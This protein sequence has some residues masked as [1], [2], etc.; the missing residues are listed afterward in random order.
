MTNTIAVQNT[1]IKK[2][3]RKAAGKPSPDELRKFAD[4]CRFRNDKINYGKLGREKL[5]T[6]NHT[7]KRWCNEYEIE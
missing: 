4:Q 7:A 6:S 5:G 1:I 2:L 3:K